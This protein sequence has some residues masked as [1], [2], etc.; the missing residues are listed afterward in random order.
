MSSSIKGGRRPVIYWA[1]CPECLTYIWVDESSVADEET[2]SCPYCEMS[3]SLMGG[4]ELTDSCRRLQVLIEDIERQIGTIPAAIDVHRFLSEQI[5]YI[6][7]IFNDRLDD[8]QADK[9]MDMVD[10]SDVEARTAS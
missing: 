7:S 5:D 2:A 1:V 3:I 10:N 6:A 8:I 4:A 9:D